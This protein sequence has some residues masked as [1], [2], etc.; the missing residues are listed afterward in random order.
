[1]KT[2]APAE[3]DKL[4]T[5]VGT[6]R[7]TKEYGELLQFIRRFRRYA[8]YN[9][10]LLHVQKPGT[11]YVASASDWELRFNRRPK[12]G[13]RPLVILRP[14][15]PVTF[16]YELNDTE[17]DPLPQEI[18]DPFLASG[19]ITDAK[20]DQFI[21]HAYYEG[22]GILMEN[23]G[24][25][26]AGQ[27]TVV[28]AM[29]QYTSKGVQKAFRMPYSVTVNGNLNPAA[30][31]ATIYHEL[32]HVFCGHLYSAYAKYLPQRWQLSQEQEEFE[33]ESVCWLL[34]ERQGIENPSAAYLSGYLENNKEIPPISIDTVLRAVG[35]VEQIWNKPLTPRKELIVNGQNG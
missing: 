11:Q 1:M 5:E 14:F 2:A 21:E 34:C 3:L 33:A 24:T 9:A 22:F 12:P 4:F 32:G 17:G 28:N 10:M 13:A 6:Y 29:A 23:Y 31:L 26:Y 7:S 15:G 35:A 18:E 25:D 8:P 27:V 30:K 16:V 19:E 20:V